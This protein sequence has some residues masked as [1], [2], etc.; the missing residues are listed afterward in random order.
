M[1]AENCKE[2]YDEWAHAYP[3]SNKVDFLGP[4]QPTHLCND[5]KEIKYINLY[6][7]DTGKLAYSST[8]RC[9]VL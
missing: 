1:S 2:V 5:E 8:G 3:S 4:I 7:E 9:E 6:Q